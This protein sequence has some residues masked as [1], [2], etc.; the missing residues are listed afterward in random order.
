M[1]AEDLALHLRVQMGCKNWNNT[2]VVRRANISR[3]T[4]YRLLSAD[5]QEAKLST[6]IK[7]ATALDTTVTELLQIYFEGTGICSE[8]TSSRIYK[9]DAGCGIDVNLPTNSLVNVGEAF[10]KTWEIVNRGGKKRRNLVLQ[11]IDDEL[12]VRMVRCGSGEMLKPCGLIPHYRSI[13]VSDFEVGEVRQISVLFTA[14]A[15]PCTTISH[16]RFFENGKM[17]GPKQLPYL[18]CHVRVVRVE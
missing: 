12:E 11:C 5:I 13:P 18:S 10:T 6:L 14:P 9:A 16:W 15:Q 8:R 3:R 17:L 7:V 4:W 1:S 2:D